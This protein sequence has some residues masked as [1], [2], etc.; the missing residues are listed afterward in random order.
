M[1]KVTGSDSE[2]LTYYDGV[3]MLADGA[4]IMKY[5]QGGDTLRFILHG[6]EIR[7]QKEGE[8]S[9]ELVFRTGSRERALIKSSFGIIETFVTAKHLS[10]RYDEA[11]A[12]AA[13]EYEQDY[14][15]GEIALY[16]VEIS[17]V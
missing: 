12:H 7:L 15:N 10:V 8:L 4:A 17:T 5:T 13:F 16:S 14:T 6:D 3:F 1:I 9:Y 11:G 2:V